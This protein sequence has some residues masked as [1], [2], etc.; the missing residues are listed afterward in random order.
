MIARAV[1]RL[2]DTI[3][4]R[5]A[6]TVVGMVLVLVACG[7]DI[8]GVGGEGTGTFALGRI[9]G[10]GSL[11]V[12]GREY[13]DGDARVVV[14]I[15]PRQ[16]QAAPL[17]ALKL[18]MQAQV[19]LAADGRIALVRVAPELVAPVVDLDL[20]TRRLVAAGQVVQLDAVPAEPTALEGLRDLADLREG[21]S[22][23][24]YGQRDAAGVIRAG[25]LVLVPPERGVRVAGRL[26]VVDAS[27]G[28]WG[29]E[30]L[31][32][33]ASSATILPAGASLHAGA[34]VVAYTADELQPDGRLVAQ[35]VAINAPP[36][37]DGTALRAGGVIARFASPEDFDVQ[38]VPVDAR[39][40]IIEGGRLADLASGRLVDVEGRVTASRLVADR[41]R[42]LPADVPPL[43][44][45]E[46][47]VGNFV[48]G[49]GFDVRQTAVEA[50]GASFAAGFGA[51]N[52]DNGVPVRVLGDLR[53]AK[54][55]AVMVEPG[56]LREGAS[57]ALAGTIERLEGATGDG[58]T[59]RL[60]GV[61]IP[62]RVRASA[63]VLGG[64]LGDLQPGTRATAR[65]TVVAGVLDAREIRLGPV[66]PEVELTGVAGN[67]EA[68]AGGGSFDV[69]PADARWTPATI[70]LGPT[71]SPT[72]LRD[73][74]VVRVRGVR[75]G[76][77]VRA[78]VV[79]ARPTQ[80]GQ[81]RLRGTVTR[82][83]SLA[84]LRLDGQRID[85]STAEFEPP[86]LA[87]GLPG[88]Y[89][90]VEGEMVDGVLRARRVSDP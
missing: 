13:D 74:L 85:A 31:L 38:G 26:R 34:R 56:P 27:R 71:G 66:Q 83:Q 78:L 8:A 80:P 19:S 22:V 43:T 55:R 39:A 76:G 69:G 37:A 75:E 84:D 90:D 15:D 10:F 48:D 30:D 70:F 1:T 50:A 24:V 25:R 62:V 14:E 59:V 47:V 7:V 67:V 81:V 42:L 46:S 52:L 51:I 79:D 45:V 12:G 23:E 49:S 73:G 44:R 41:V 29:I 40:A 3:R 28:L 61:S 21:D 82:F 53:G 5:A 87:N 32:I 18:G 36:V 35:A 33:D 86:G 2:A 9:D 68:D 65:G 72:D 20:G 17:S 63:L 54:V 58:I 57:L 88:A 89:V 60:Q 16:P 64:G 4:A 77:V 6:A 11:I